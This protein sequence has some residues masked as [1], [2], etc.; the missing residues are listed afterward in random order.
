MCMITIQRTERNEIAREAG[1]VV[2]Y[3]IPDREREM[4]FAVCFGKLMPSVIL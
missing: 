3:E 1:A 4:S 2:R